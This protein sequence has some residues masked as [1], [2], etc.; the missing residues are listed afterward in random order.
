MNEIFENWISPDKLTDL[1][2]SA[3]LVLFADNQDSPILLLSVANIRRAAKNKLAEQIEKTKKADLKSITAKVYYK[4]YPCKF[5][6][7]LEHYNAVKKIF[8]SN[9]KDHI[10]FVR[11]RFIETDLNEKIPF[12]SITRKPFFKNGEKVL[13]PFPS[14]KS[15]AVFLKTIEDVFKLCKR[16]DLV[17]N[18][19]QSASC[20]YLQM[21]ACCGVCGGKIN[22]QDYQNIAK[23]AFAAGAAAAKQIEKFGADMQRASKE[24]NFEKAAELK[25]KIEKLS[26]LKKQTYRW[27]GNLEKLKI[28]H[29][30]KSAK[31]KQ[32]D[33]KKKKQSFAVFVMDFFEIIDLGDFVIENIDKIAETIEDAMAKLNNSRQETND[34]AKILERFA[35]IS[36]FLYRTNPPG[37]WINAAEGLDKT[38]F[39]QA[40]NGRFKF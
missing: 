25:K 9:Y 11:P 2:S 23:E 15:A 29:I 34:S 20:P 26:A 7:A 12:F 24:L 37:L 28:V 40:F 30:D 27:T 38:M 1:P 16:N 3:G 13:G 31:I 4:T 19:Q 32:Q 21:D 10:A 18:P 36:Y 14:Q 5:R 8:A 33:S 17:N 39:T 35:I 6:L 22:P